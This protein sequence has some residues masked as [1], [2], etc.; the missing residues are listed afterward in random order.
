MNREM[1]FDQNNVR[2]HDENLRDR[3]ENIRDRNQD[4]DDDYSFANQT[5]FTRIDTNDEIQ[6]FKLDDFRMKLRIPTEVYWALPNDYYQ[7]KHQRK[8]VRFLDVESRNY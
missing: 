3:E 7:R 8:R 5:F 4:D 2:D 1:T 6:L